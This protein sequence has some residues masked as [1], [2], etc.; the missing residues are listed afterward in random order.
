MA[1]NLGSVAPYGPI[2]GAR[3]RIGACHCWFP[4]S[5]PQKETNKKRATGRALALGDCRLMVQHNNQPIVSGRSW[6][7]VSAEAS[8]RGSVLGD[9]VPLLGVMIQ[10]MEIFQKL[11]TQ[12]P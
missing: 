7:N 10:T 9:T 11:N 6:G 12:Q 3:C 4:C 8:G 2:Q 5:G 1:T